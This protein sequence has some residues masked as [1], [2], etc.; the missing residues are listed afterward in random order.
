MVLPQEYHVPCG[1][2]ALLIGKTAL[3]GILL[4]VLREWQK[5]EWQLVPV[6]QLTVRNR[7]LLEQHRAR[8]PVEYIPLT[9]GHCH[10]QLQL[11][12][13]RADWRTELKSVVPGVSKVT[14]IPM[15]I[16]VA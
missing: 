7:L 11:C 2:V 14:H 16:L 4:L 5:F 8:C 10:L 9:P 13:G 12:Q 15:L 3:I 1:P 6:T